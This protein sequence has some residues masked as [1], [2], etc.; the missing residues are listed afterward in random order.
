MVHTLTSVLAARQGGLGSWDEE[1]VLDACP[2]SESL[3]AALEQQRQRPRIEAQ[4][5][6]VSY[7]PGSRTCIFCHS[8]VIWFSGGSA[9]SF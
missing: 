9:I 2:V 3:G 1:L 8:R 7:S 5:G 4:A 6:G